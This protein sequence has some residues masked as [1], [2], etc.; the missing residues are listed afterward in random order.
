MNSVSLAPHGV[1][2]PTMTDHTQTWLAELARRLDDLA[3]R[4]RQRQLRTVTALPAHRIQVG[5]RT[6]LNL[7][8]NDYLGAGG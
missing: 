4:S 3:A 2:K 8:S 7:A 6:Y 1:A 5:D